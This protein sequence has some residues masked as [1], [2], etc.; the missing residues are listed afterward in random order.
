[1]KDEYPSLIK[2]L[3]RA[4]ATAACPTAVALG[5]R[6]RYFFASN[7]GKFWKMS[8]RITELAR[9]GSIKRLW[10]GKDGAFVLVKQSG[11]IKFN[12]NGNYNGLGEFLSD[13]K[14]REKS[15]KVSDF[16]SYHV[17]IMHVLTR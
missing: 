4:N 17:R 16:H 12:L 6:G 3:K 11:S 8:R 1:L 5:V 10:L 14:A 9:P 7:K 13:L 15:I 2:K